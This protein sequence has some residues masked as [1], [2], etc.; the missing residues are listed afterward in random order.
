MHH[1]SQI[2][3]GEHSRR[4]TAGEWFEDRK[5]GKAARHPRRSEGLLTV[6][7]TLLRSANAFRA[8]CTPEHEQEVRR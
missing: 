6:L 3:M 4:W 8:R 7:E 5:S 2:A 1:M